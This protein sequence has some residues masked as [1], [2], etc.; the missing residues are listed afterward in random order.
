MIFVCRPL[1]WCINSFACL[2]L[3]SR[4]LCTLESWFLASNLQNK[5]PMC[6]LLC[7]GD[8]T[9]V[10]LYKKLHQSLLYCRVATSCC[11]GLPSPRFDA[12]DLLRECCLLWTVW[13][14]VGGGLS[15]LIRAMFVGYYKCVIFE[16]ILWANTHGQE[17]LKV[18]WETFTFI[19]FWP[20]T[21]WPR[22]SPP[23]LK[24]VVLLSSDAT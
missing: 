22:V 13:C 8:M 24:S 7:G 5:I 17:L 10:L 19:I 1:V 3:Y 20:E 21:G 11:H 16:S 12:K 15:I 14:A 4:W 9:V 2:L 6:T 18:A 23:H